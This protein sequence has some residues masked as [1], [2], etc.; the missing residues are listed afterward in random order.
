M[1][2]VPKD[3]APWAEV[4]IDLIV[5][6]PKTKEGFQHIFVAKD[7][8]TKFVCMVPLR[9]KTATEVG[10]AMVDEV[11]CR[12]GVARKI[13]SDRGR[14]FQNNIQAAINGM[15]RQYQQFTTA[16]HPQAN[17][18]VENQ[19]RTIK[20][21]LAAYINMHHSDWDVFLPLITHAYN[22][23]VNDATGYSPFRALYGREAA[24]PTDSWIKASLGVS[25]QTL[26]TYV[27]GLQR[28]LLETWGNIAEAI[29]KGH[30]W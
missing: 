28:V 4:H 13:Y 26:S 2:H 10:K 27:S 7:S 11:Y 8:L 17:G 5:E 20:D 18:Q 16:Y 15:L 19:N 12:F 22:T 24:Q 23:T 25:D 30:Q 14:E 29:A 9:T 3:A 1:I 21:A 6:L